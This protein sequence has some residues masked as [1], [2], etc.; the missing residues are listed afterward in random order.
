MNNKKLLSLYGLKWNPFIPELPT[1]ALLCT[2]RMEEFAW[3][4]EHL[5]TDGGFALITGDSGTGKSVAL[6]ILAERLGRL[7]DVTVGVLT[8]PQSKISDFNRELGETFAVQLS[9]SNRWGGFKALREKW[10][11]H[12]ESSLLRPVLLVDEAQQMAAAVLSELR[13]LSSGQFDSL[14]YLTVVLC[15]DQR[16]ME[17]FRQAVIPLGVYLKEPAF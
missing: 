1:E 10:K 14:S 2:P 12:V 6:R 4:V 5:V 11:A 3:R 17:L 15:G 7:R 8:R 13:L 16:L 9:P